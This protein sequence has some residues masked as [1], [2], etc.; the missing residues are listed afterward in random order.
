LASALEAPEAEA[1]GQSRWTWPALAAPGVTWLVLL[2]LTPFYTILAVAMGT[3]HPIFLTPRPEWNPLRWNPT[4]FREVL[5]DLFGGRLGVIAL[6]TIGYVVVASLLCI[7]IGYPVAYFVSRRAGRW[8]GLLLV[9]LLAPFWINYL[10]RMLAWVNL[11]SP[12]GY[13]NRMVSWFGVAPVDWLAGR[14]STVI[15]GMVY[16]YVPFF[17][18]PLYAALDRIDHHT[19]EAA[20][21]LGASPLGA[22]RRVTLPL[23]KQGVLAG[24][25]IIMLPMFG[26][27]YTPNLLSGSPRT[28]LIGNEI[29]QFITQSTSQGG[30]GAALTIILMAFVAI[31]MAYYLVAVARSSREARR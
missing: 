3:R 8:R 17:I 2:F 18:L 24:L 7:L 27:Y 22:F 21:D 13:V 25:V 12:D 23:S 15:L 30:K 6:R 10:M 31:L 29:D 1:V 9:L 20:R 16:G 5:A 11:L 26:D 14:P 28:R 19:L 4:P